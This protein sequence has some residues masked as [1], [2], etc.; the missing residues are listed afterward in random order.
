MSNN[1]K[2]ELQRE[3]LLT[4]YD[5]PNATNKEIAELCD[6]SASYVSNV[7]N[8]FDDYTEFEIMMD[9]QD[10][11]METMFGEG[12]FRQG[13]MTGGG[14]TNQA[15]LAE[16]WEEMPNN[17]PGIIIKSTVLVALLY[18]VYQFGITLV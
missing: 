6:C 2:T 1:G 14:Q 18:A 11:E 16:Q 5:N 7:K 9:R 12:I 15:G 4:W 13:Q 17:A 3:I 10:K 8:R